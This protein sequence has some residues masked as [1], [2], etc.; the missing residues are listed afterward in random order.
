[1]LQ[2]A[3]WDRIKELKNLLPIQITNLAKFVGTI[4][5]DRGLPISVLKVILDSSNNFK[6][7]FLKLN[8]KRNYFMNK[9]IYINVG[10]KFFY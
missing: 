6:T 5:L 7:F 8:K 2:C 1:M 3:I 9:N 10:I 4:V